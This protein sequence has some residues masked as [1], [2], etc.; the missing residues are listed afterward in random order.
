MTSDGKPCTHRLPEASLLLCS[1]PWRPDGTLGLAANFDNGF[2]DA[3]RCHADVIL[4]KWR[5]GGAGRY[6][7]TPS[8]SSPTGPLQSSF[9]CV[10][11]DPC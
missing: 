1:T 6:S 3:C 2:P 4:R 10:S 8:R 7:R 9:T 5:K 11:R